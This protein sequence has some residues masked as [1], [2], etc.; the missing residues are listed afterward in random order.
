MS[1]TIPHTRSAVI[2]GLLSTAL[3]LTGCERS[4]VNGIGSYTPNDI[5]PP[6]LDVSVDECRI[7]EWGWVTATGLVQNRT[8]DVA[9]YEVVVAFD[10]D[11][12]RAG[13]GSDWIRDVDAGTAAR[14]RASTHLGDEATGMTD[15]RVLTVNRWSAQTM[16][17]AP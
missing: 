4:E 16:N 15:C 10:V 9:S 14:F 17:D 8:D 3:A 2:V 13:Q 7:G 1:V 6:Q 5:A 12:V 11:D